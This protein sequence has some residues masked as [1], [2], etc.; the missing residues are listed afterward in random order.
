MRG[1]LGIIAFNVLKLVEP[2]INWE[3]VEKVRTIHHDARECYRAARL[4]L[5]LRLRKDRSCIG[6]TPNGNPRRSGPATT[7]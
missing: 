5:Q 4:C 2:C 1:T 6:S 7:A 3:L